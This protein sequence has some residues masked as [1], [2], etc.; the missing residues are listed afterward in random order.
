MARWTK[1]GK[2]TYEQIIKND[3]AIDKALTALLHNV[4]KD[5]VESVKV[6]IAS[7]YRAGWHQRNLRRKAV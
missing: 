7:G 4:D 1:G 5:L 6:L 3:P 2:M